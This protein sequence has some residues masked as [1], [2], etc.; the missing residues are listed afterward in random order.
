MLCL[1]Q[2]NDW[3]FLNLPTTN[4]L[5]PPI[6]LSYCLLMPIFH[7]AC[8]GPRLQPSL[9][10][11]PH[12]SLSHVS[13]LSCTSQASSFCFSG[14]PFSLSL[15][16]FPCPGTSSPAYVSIWPLA[17][18]N[19][20]YQLEPSGSRDPEHLTCRH[21]SSHVIWEPHNASIKPNLLRQVVPLFHTICMKKGKNPCR[22]CVTSRTHSYI[23]LIFYRK[24]KKTQCELSSF[25]FKHI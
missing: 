19:F 7:L 6:F 21:V 24:R 18:S 20:I 13:S 23:K 4:I 11:I 15:S 16:C 12:S 5:S 1:K 3:A 8:P 17:A 10:I 25:Y 22:I 9:A 14:M 2:S